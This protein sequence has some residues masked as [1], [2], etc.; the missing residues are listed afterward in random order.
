VRNCSFLSV[1]SNSEYGDGVN[2][3][4]R[5]EDFGCVTPASL[6]N[7]PT[8]VIQ[9]EGRQSY[10]ASSPLEIEPIET[11]REGDARDRAQFSSMGM[12]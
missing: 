4:A 12:A 8:R 5:L 11:H 7:R 6:P 10:N 2:V 9:G 1:R 3:A